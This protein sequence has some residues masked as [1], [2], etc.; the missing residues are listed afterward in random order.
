MWFVSRLRFPS[1]FP[2]A[3]DTAHNRHRSFNPLMLIHPTPSPPYA[4]MGLSLSPCDG[5]LTPPHYFNKRFQSAPR[6]GRNAKGVV[7]V[8]WYM[9]V[10]ICIPGWGYNHSIY[11][12]AA[13]CNILR[14]FSIRLSHAQGIP[15]GQRLC[16]GN[17]IGLP[18]A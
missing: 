9:L 2:H 8:V 18:H 3:R 17:G 11:H 16:L 13:D 6:V 12:F 15:L 1:F 14:L 7:S 4:E 5:G 10:L